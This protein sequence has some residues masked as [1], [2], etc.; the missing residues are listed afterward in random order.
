MALVFSVAV[1]NTMFTEPFASQVAD[2]L[3]GMFGDDIDF[4]SQTERHSDELGWSGWS[5]LQERGVEALGADKLPHFLSM[6][7][8]HGCYLPVKTDIGSL[9]FSDDSPNLDVGALDNL[10]PELESLGNALSLP[11]EDSALDELFQKYIE[12]DDLI[13]ED[14]DVQTFTQLLPLARFARAQRLPL[15]VVK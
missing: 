5:E 8:W 15:W 2:T 7:A 3:R 10:I 1:P 14:M 12:D 11:T 6:E 13:D 4:N 9:E